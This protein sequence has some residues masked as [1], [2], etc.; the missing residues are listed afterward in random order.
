MEEDSQAIGERERERG[1]EGDRVGIRARC[2]W[3]ERK[4]WKKVEKPSND[5]DWDFLFSMLNDR[6]R[7][8]GENRG[9]IDYAIIVSE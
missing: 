1:S 5:F 9:K 7:E 6:G 8:R 3:L 2:F 4:R